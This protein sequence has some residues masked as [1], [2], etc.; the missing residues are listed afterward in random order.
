MYKSYFRHIVIDILLVI[1]TVAF[2][3]FLISQ[4]LNAQKFGSVE[5]NT[6][7]ALIHPSYPS[8]CSDNR[9]LITYGSVFGE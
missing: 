8:S 6:H 1:I 5:K 4:I 9:T 2:W 3:N 7:M